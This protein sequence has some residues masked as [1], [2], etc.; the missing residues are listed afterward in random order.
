MRQT[1]LAH[2]KKRKS[3]DCNQG[4]ILISISNFQQ[5][6]NVSDIATILEWMNVFC[7]FFG[8]VVYR[9]SRFFYCWCKNALPR[10]KIKC[11][12]LSKAKKN[13]Q[14]TFK[15]LSRKWIRFF[16]SVFVG[17]FSVVY[18]K[19]AVFKINRFASLQ[20]YWIFDCSQSFWCLSLS[21]ISVSLW[22]VYFVC[23]Y[24]VF[25]FWICWLA[26]LHNS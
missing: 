10:Y 3:N 22:I 2:E 8:H 23:S 6:K 16:I 4:I 9:G 26:S 21:V 24:T 20:W 11:A 12:E 1:S 18:W 7:F 17:A 25:F 5:N 15:K 13:T 19:A 14:E